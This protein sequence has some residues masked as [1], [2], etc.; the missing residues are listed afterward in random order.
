MKHLYIFNT[1]RRG[2]QYGIGTYTDQLI[3]CAFTMGMAITIVELESSSEVFTVKHQKGVRHILIPHPVFP[4]P[5]N[6][7][8]K[9]D[10]V[11]QQNITYILKD[12]I[13]ESENN[14]FHLNRMNLLSLTKDLKSHFSG[15]IILT[16]HYTEWSFSY[17]GNKKALKKMLAKIPEDLSEEEKR[18]S[19]SM[20]YEKELMNSY[21]DKIIA[22]AQH[23]YNDLIS[24]YKINPDKIHLIN[25]ALIDVSK[26][27]SNDR[28]QKLKQK[29]N[30]SGNEIVLIHAG[31]LE[32]IKGTFILIEAFSEV[33]QKHPD[34][35][36]FIA[37]SGDFDSLF[38]YS[39]NIW[40]KIAFT[41]FIDRKILHELYSIADIGIVPSIHEEFGYVAIEMMMHKLPI[42]VNNTTGLS[43]II[44]NEHNGIYVHLKQ[45]KPYL[46]SSA[47]NLAEK[48]DILIQDKLLRV[49]LGKNARK[50]FLDRYDNLRFQEKMKMVYN[51]LDY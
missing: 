12:Y 19:L 47:K 20:D 30:I 16:V 39:K 42:I 35:R 7:I 32:E 31:R 25:N 24:L 10:E 8:L 14:I 21:C 48:I 15:K 9:Y 34:T 50:S 38:Y 22:I 6:D 36:L 27:K 1:N 33:L 17:L 28:K 4:T 46:K 18:L 43:E 41:G 37:G 49:E 5:S 29:Y 40:S 23:S 2:S 51:S 11:Y 3:Q 26:R 44:Q 13:T 45:G